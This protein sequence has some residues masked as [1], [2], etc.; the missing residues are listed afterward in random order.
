MTIE[1]AHRRVIPADARVTEWIAPDGWPIRRFDRAGAGRGAILFQTGRGD[2]FEK[3]LETFAYW[4]GRG[5][6]VT[7]FD[8]RG[9]GGSGRLSRNP[10]V[11]H[12][13]DFAPWIA[14]LAAFWR[15]WAAE[16]SGPRVA[17]GHSMGGYLVLRGMVE[18]AIRPD[19]AVLIAPM[20]GLRS[21]VSP[22]VGALVARAMTALGDPAR[23]A[24]KGHERP[25]ARDRSVLL[26]AD[27]ER[28]ADEAHIYTQSP[29]LRLGPPS[30]A[31]LAAAFEGT[32]RLRADPRLAD[33]RVPVQML[34]AERDA[35]VDPAAACAVA[36]RLPDSRLVRFGPE[37]A[38]EILRE[39]DPVRDRALA[40]IDWFLDERASGRRS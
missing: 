22:K 33:L 3:Y 26:T 2:V 10:N 8:W 28:Y 9:Q 15:E 25:G 17:M 16:H 11:G 35:L 24:W 38:H 37:S 29:A 30:W 39:A 1:P 21:P 36:A 12:A 13:S 19:A 40:A 20:L 6:S 32:A 7:A 14:D 23:A 5:W 31:W 27:P 4:H 18:D 34:V